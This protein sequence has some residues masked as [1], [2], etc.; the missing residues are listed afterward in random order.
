MLDIG[1]DVNMNS[2]LII[3]TVLGVSAKNSGQ[4]DI[5]GDLI[6]YI[7]SGGVVV[8]KINKELRQIEDQRFFAASSN[9]NSTLNDNSANAYLNLYDSSH[10]HDQEPQKDSFGFLINSNPTIVEG[11]SY[12]NITDSGLN[13]SQNSPAS[14]PSKLQP[15]P[16]SPS[17]LKDRVR[18][19]NCLALSPN[20]KLLAIGEVGY[21]PRILIYSLAPDLSKSPVIMI[22]DHS[23]GISN[24]KFSTN[25]K[26]L[27]SL[28]LINDGMLNIWLVNGTSIYL[29]S[30][31]RCSSIISDV[32][33]FDNYLITIGIRFVKVWTVEKFNQKPQTK[34]N[35]LKGKNII[36]GD[37]LNSHFH[38]CSKLNDDEVLITT[39]NNLFVLK[40][41][42]EFKLILLEAPKFDFISVYVNHLKGEV[43]F[44]SKDYEFNF[45]NVESLVIAFNTTSNSPKSLSSSPTRVEQV[46]KKDFKLFSF[47]NDHILFL[48]NLTS[49]DLYN[50]SQ[51]K[52]QS[53][54][55]PLMNNLAGVRSF[56]DKWIVFSSTGEVSELKLPKSIKP[57][58]THNLFSLD[59]FVNSLTSLGLYENE[60]ALGD[61]FGLLY[62]FERMNEDYKMIFQIKAH[63]YS[64]TDIS[65]FAINGRKYLCSISRDRM[66]Q[67][68]DKAEKWN[69]LQTLP[70][71]NGKLLKLG[72]W[73]QMIFV[74]S[75]DRTVSVHKIE[76]GLVKLEKNISLKSSP[77]TMGITDNELIISTNDK[78]LLI[79]N[80][81][82][83]EFQRS[84]KLYDD[85]INE[86]LLIENFVV[87]NKV[88]FT[89]STDKSLRSIDYNSGK[90]LT[91]NFGHLD[92]ILYFDI[93]NNN[94]ITFGSDGCLF[95]WK[96]RENVEPKGIK[97]IS[98]SNDID[99]EPLLLA[100]VTRKIIP[101]SPVRS[102]KDNIRLGKIS[103]SP[104]PV[105]TF[106]STSHSPTGKLTNATIKRIEA[107]SRSAS[108]IRRSNFTQKASTIKP[109]PT[110]MN[111]KPLL[112][113]S[114]SVSKV[115]KFLPIT[116]KRKDESSNSSTDIFGQFMDDIN[117]MKRT[118]TN[119]ELN[120][121]QVTLV[122]KE[123]L[124]TLQ[125]LDFQYDHTDLLERYSEQLIILFHN[126]LN[127]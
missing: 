111:E 109:L 70:L 97:N 47:D 99:E 41:G 75:S 14:S 12:V 46:N 54:I 127:K 63:E 13:M 100:K 86:S 17:K 95:I 80:L 103:S 27:S 116:D 48:S 98:L 64:I 113:S 72:H 50:I 81:P 108:P 123:L 60:I 40:L 88:I 87:L 114:P 19:I 120:K 4:F 102:E 91:T 38:S 112:T 56:D 37:H 18:T 22:Y 34:A 43:W 66:I 3:D 59:A 21:Q 28:G 20:G 36:L 45:I 25:S 7:A 121:L 105:R 117:D 52:V 84:L 33:W 16:I 15:V 119:N 8:S 124:A 118:I 65:I 61:K 49:L 83:L 115:T 76:D 107:R 94:L 106:T 77:I 90:P 79:Y 23:F 42:N 26:F 32:L 1:Q 92:P 110:E 78:N 58:L 85:S 104:S 57:L 11:N 51:R 31:N 10:L 125:L 55:S 24:L 82:S 71:H 122:K 9:I 96:I 44:C 126:K 35:I 5:Q 2:R 93:D 73:N 62:I 53:L 6:A 101:S 68:F 29:N 89:S 69:L 67:I 30:S 39:D 74:C